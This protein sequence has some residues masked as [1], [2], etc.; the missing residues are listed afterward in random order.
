MI[1]RIVRMTF[2][3]GNIGDFINLFTRTSSKIAE[4]KG[5]KHL[6]LMSEPSNK[7][8]FC[9]YS[10]WDSETDL[11]NYRNSETFNTIWGECKTYFSERPVAF[12]LEKFI[13]VKELKDSQS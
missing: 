11:N 6:E 8:V 4:M 3:E 2:K 12:S 1:V 7:R 13:S 9:T 10:I 5:C